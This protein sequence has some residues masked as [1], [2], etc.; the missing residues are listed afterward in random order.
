MEVLEFDPND[1]V[2]P[3]R[4][5]KDYGDVDSLA[6]S[7][8]DHGQIH[9]ILITYTDS[10]P[11]LV[12]G[13]R[14]VAACKKAGKKVQATVKENCTPVELKELELRENLDRKDMT[15]QEKV[16]GQAELHKL[17]IEQFGQHKGGQSSSGW[18]TKDTAEMIGEAPTT[19]KDSVK[20]AEAMKIFPELAASKSQHEARKKLDKMVEKLAIAELADRRKEVATG[21]AVL[22]DENFIVGDAF[23]GLKAL[24]AESVDF[25]N[26]DTPYGIDLREQK[27]IQSDSRTTDSY[28]EWDKE[29]YLRLVPDENTISKIWLDGSDIKYL[30]CHFEG[31]AWD[32]MVSAF[33]ILR[34]DRWMVFWYGQ[35]WQALVK[36]ALIAAGFKLDKIPACWYGGPGAAQTMAPETNLG[37]AY[38]QFFICR[39][40]NPVLLKRGRPNVFAYDKVAAQ[41]KIHP[42]EKPLEL[43]VDIYET[44]VLP[45]QHCCSPFIGSGNDGRAAYKYGCSWF[46]FDKNSDVK[47]RFL[48]RVEQDMKD[49]LYGGK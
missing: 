38:E 19:I 31:Y 6:Q 7:I 15:W 34:S 48:L 17:K 37:R 18:S 11:T 44:F 25:I 2:V 47:N 42:T 28:E 8:T 10:K 14:R 46:G 4:M 36:A 26:L 29:D 41:K 43:M 12:A 35:E 39:K 5:R 22:A 21:H 45:G 13:G 3:E 32:A 20:I 24:L 23:A 9:P 33:R 1:I 49:G 27:K 40:G 16:N 30:N